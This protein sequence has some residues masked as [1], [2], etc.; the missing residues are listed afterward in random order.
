MPQIL[1]GTDFGD[2]E[3]QGCE[4]KGRQSNRTVGKRPEKNLQIG[5]YPNGQ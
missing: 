2:S 4:K 3:A 1:E 5:Y